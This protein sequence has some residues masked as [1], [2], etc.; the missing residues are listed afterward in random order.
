MGRTLILCCMVFVMASTASADVFRF[1]YTKGEKYRILS[2]VRESV[3]LNGRLSHESDILDKIAVSVTDTRGDAGFHDVLFQ[4]S[5]M[6]YGSRAT[7]DWA[8]E[9][10][11]LFWRDA[12]G[13]YTMDGSYFMV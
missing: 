7:Y 2:Q 10:T 4:T 5:E 8:E 13:S 6:A 9:Y 12:R 11:S 1:R 3:Y